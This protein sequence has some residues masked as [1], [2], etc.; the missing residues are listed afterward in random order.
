MYG[1]HVACHIKLSVDYDTRGCHHVSGSVT[2]S[3]VLISCQLLFC[4]Y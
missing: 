3:I 4:Y 1:H 2:G